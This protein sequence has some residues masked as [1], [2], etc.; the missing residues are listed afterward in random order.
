MDRLVRALDALTR[1]AIAAGLRFEE[2]A[3][4]LHETGE[5]DARAVSFFAQAR[6]IFDVA[7]AADAASWEYRANTN[8]APPAV[9][10]D[11]IPS[12]T[13]PVARLVEDATIAARQAGISAIDAV[14]AAHAHGLRPLADEL[15]AAIPLLYAIP[16]E[17]AFAAARKRVAS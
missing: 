16:G 14:L 17:E 11:G 10:P 3:R 7:H 13:K 15:L 12:T 4:R 5:Q 8:V 6:C 2:A 1:N 9:G